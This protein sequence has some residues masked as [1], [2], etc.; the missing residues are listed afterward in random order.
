MIDVPGIFRT[1][2]QDTTIVNDISMVRNMVTGFMRI[3]RSVILVVIPANV[4]IATQEIA[5]IAGECDRDEKRTLGVFSKP[6]LVDKGAEAS[7][8]D[9]LD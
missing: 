8:V 4:D 1:T 3:R 6:D 7:V 9:I 5:E 2:T